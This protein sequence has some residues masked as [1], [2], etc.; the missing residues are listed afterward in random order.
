MLNKWLRRSSI[1]VVG[2]M[3]SAIVIVMVARN[4]GNILVVN[5]SVQVLQ[6]DLNQVARGQ[7]QTGSVSVVP[8]ANND[9]PEGDPDGD[10]VSNADEFAN[11]TD[12]YNADTD[13]DGQ[14]DQW[15]IENGL[16]PTNGTDSQVAAAHVD[17]D[18]SRAAGTNPNSEDTDGDGLPDEWEILYGL[19]PTIWEGDQGGEG[20]PDGDDLI[21]MDEWANNTDPTTPDTDGDGLPDHWEVENGTN[22]IDAN[23]DNG[24]EGD[25]DQDGLTN[26]EELAHHTDPSNA[27]TDVD[28]LPDQWEIAFGLDPLSNSGDDGA[29]GDPDGDGYNNWA[30]Y[31]N[32]TDPRKVDAPTDDDDPTIEPST[33]QLFLP[34]MRR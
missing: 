20:D 5:D 2:I 33:N 17:H 25:L 1:S 7:V 22:P 14:P 11:F 27:D 31:R 30:E 26:L 12:P 4:P 32:V 6:S 13:G 19:D 9:S 10:G 23:G 3:L 34:E 16:D 21:N 29:S 28:T 24:G 18:A 8:S 15:E